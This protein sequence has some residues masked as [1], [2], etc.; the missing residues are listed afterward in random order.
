MYAV[1]VRTGREKWKFKAK[2]AVFSSPAI[3][4]GVVY[5]G[6]HDK[7]LYAVDIQTG[8][9]KWKL[10]IG[11]EVWSPPAVADGVVYFGSLDGHLYAVDIQTGQEKWKFEVGG[12]VKGSPVVA[13][14]VES[15]PEAEVLQHLGCEYGQGK[16]F[17]APLGMEAA[18]SLL[19]LK[20]GD[21]I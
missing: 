13:E 4:D 18:S 17:H 15:T 19:R 7:H 14:G 8:Q 16:N 10:E 20:S 5:F 6:S 3:A 2:L 21:S 9:E 12:I 11:W 1:D